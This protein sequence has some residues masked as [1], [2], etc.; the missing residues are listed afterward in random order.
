VVAI[1]RV[2]DPHEIDVRSDVTSLGLFFQ[3]E[4]FHTTAV[5]TAP[6]ATQEEALEHDTAL[7]A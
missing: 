1:Q 4:P 6:T 7:G 2:E 3:V 5:P